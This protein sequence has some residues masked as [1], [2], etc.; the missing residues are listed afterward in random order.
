LKKSKEKLKKS[1]TGFFEGKNYFF[2]G[3]NYLAVKSD[4]PFL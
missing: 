4:K 2:K 3:I 1:L